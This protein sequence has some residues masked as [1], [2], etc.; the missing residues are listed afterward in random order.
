MKNKKP[1]QRS[2]GRLLKLALNAGFPKGRKAAFRKQNDTEPAC[3]P[4]DAGKERK[5][6][7][8]LRGEEVDCNL[9]VCKIKATQVSG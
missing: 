2:A 5:H 3:Y 4:E 7:A 1:A 6:G 8:T 9:E